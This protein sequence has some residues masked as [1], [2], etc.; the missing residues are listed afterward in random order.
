MNALLVA[1]GSHG[2]VHP[3]VG[4]GLTL[5]DRGHDVTFVTN[6][7][8][9]PLV[10][11][12][13]LDF[14]PVGTADDYRELASNPDMWHPMRAPYVVADAMAKTLPPVF[15][16]VVSRYVPDETLVVAST[17]GIGARVA[18][19]VHG[20]PLVSVHLQPSILRTLYDTPR[21]FGMPMR[22]WMPKWYKKTIWRVAD[23]IVDRVL[24]GPVN[25]FR[26][27]F[28]LPPVKRIM[29]EW[30]N[31]PRMLLGLFPEWF[32]PRQPDWPPQLRLTGFPLYDE[33]GVAPMP[34]ALEKFLDE[35]EPP[36]AFTPGSAMWQG[37][38]FF[39][40]AVGACVR[41]KRR[42]VLLSRHR[43]HVPRD[44]PPGMIH[45]D[46]APFSELLPRCAG[47]VHHG[48]IGTCAQAMACGLPQLVTPMAHDQLDNA[49]RMERLGVA[50]WVA[51]KRFTAARGAKVLGEVLASREVAEACA[52]TKARFRGT[53]PLEESARLIEGLLGSRESPL[54]PAL[55]RE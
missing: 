50:R 17:L 3:F 39:E 10:R 33:R 40:A 26:A 14:A 35:G 51:A 36:V 43:D 19:E 25:E 6:P 32:G 28:G 23:F 54:T 41:L 38:N 49:V 5:R 52:K 44:L 30:W 15:D 37:R 16:Q 47:L 4:L 31:S 18:Q 13:G 9:E 48:G 8:F 22:P 1:I 42:G 46:F 53:E 7:H 34:A 11:R 27:T 45:V 2:D 55:S 12:V 24:A 21:Y 20:I 29:D